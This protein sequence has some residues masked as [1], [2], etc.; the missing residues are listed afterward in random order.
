MK[1][2]IRSFCIFLFMIISLTGFSARGGLAFGGNFSAFAVEEQELK[3][4]P[5]V[6]N[7]KDVTLKGNIKEDV[8]EERQLT[9]I[10][11]IGIRFIHQSGFPSYIEQIYPNSPASRGGLRP[12]DLIFAIDGVRTD[13]L[14]SDSVYQL[15]A[16]DPGTKVKVFITRGQTMFNVELQRED[17][18]NLSPEIQNRYLSGPIAV[19][20]SPKDFIPYH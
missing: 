2:L 10:G 19:P 20:V 4:A 9:G 12:K 17:L 3:S 13:H 11:V 5:W 8:S 18:A 14:S 6:E 16:G 1:K 7:I 15:L